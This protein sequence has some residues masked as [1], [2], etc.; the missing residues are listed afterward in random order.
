MSREAAAHADLRGYPANDVAADVVEKTF[1][2]VSGWRP[3][4]PRLRVRAFAG[5][6]ALDSIT[7]IS[8]FAA[9]NWMRNSPPNPAATLFGFAVLAIYM[10]IAGNRHAF[11]ADA[12]RSPFS[13]ISRGVRALVIAIAAAILAAFLTKTSVAF[14]RLTIG[15]GAVAAVVGMCVFRYW[16]V[17]HLDTIVGGNPFQTVVIVDGAAKPPKG[18]FPVVVVSDHELD[19]T[20]NDPRMYLRM[21]EKLNGADRVL[22]VCEPARR[23]AWARALKGANV[24][25]ELYMPELEA[26]LPTGIAIDHGSP[27]VIVASGPLNLADRA[28]KRAFDLVVAVSALVVLSPLFLAVALWIK[29]DSKGPVLFRQERIGRANQMFKI[30]KFRSMRVDD[31]DDVGARS[32]SRDDD[33]VTRVGR[34][35]RRTSI[36]ELPQLLNVIRGDM[37]IVGPRP[38]ATASKAQDKLFWEVDQ[39]YWERHAAKPGLTG[40]AQV[41]GFRGAT[42]REI[43]LRNRLASD[44]EYLQGW[45]IWRDLKIL[46]F[47]ARVVLHENAF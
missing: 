26:L 45:S 36:D 7:I 19:P 29:L 6:M 46:F 15:M 20:F 11:A 1:E 31:C 33:R 30:L 43:D 13:A 25:G 22:V 24:Q 41:R 14:P 17:T 4:A 18:D 9:A 37:S 8:S 35:I 16:F 12:L 27:S 10:L 28:T 39:R 44:L 2:P 3:S 23:L 47:T 42:A 5:L 34:F 38:H 21:A 40:L 32:T